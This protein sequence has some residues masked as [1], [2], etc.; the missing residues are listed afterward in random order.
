MKAGLV[1]SGTDP[2]LRALSG[3]NVVCVLLDAEASENT[4][5]K[6]ADACI[7]RGIPVFLTDP[8][9]LGS[10][11]G[12]PERRVA[13]LKP[14]KLSERFMELANGEQKPYTIEE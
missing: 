1:M 6:V 13:A 5:K 10:T 3:G 2:V 14:G 4:R 8:D 12:R 9:R 7:H 11:L